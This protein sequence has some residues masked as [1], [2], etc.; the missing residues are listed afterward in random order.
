MRRYE[1]KRLF[2]GFPD[3]VNIA[4][5]CTML[6]IGK[7]SAYKLV[8]SGAI[9]SVRVGRKILIPKSSVI[10]F[11]QGSDGGAIDDGQLAG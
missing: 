1:M 10:E 3:V 9:H 8:S 5:L 11:V 6:D 2:K 7:N 4:T